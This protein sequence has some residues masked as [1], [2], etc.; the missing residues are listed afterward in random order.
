MPQV[1]ADWVRERV[2]PIADGPGAG[3]V[4]VAWVGRTSTD[5][6]QDP[7]GSLLR[8]LRVSQAA[9]PEGCVIVAHFY[10]VESGRKDLAHRGNGA[11]WSVPI[12]RDGGV[13][14]LLD[15]AEGPAPGF[16]AVICEQIDRIARGT[17]YGTLI[18]HRLQ[19]AG[20]RLWAADEPFEVT[21]R[22][23]IVEPSSILTRRVKQGV[24]EWY[25]LDMLKRARGGYETHT[26]QGYSVGKAPYGY[27]AN[28]VT[29]RE[30]EQVRG[31]GNRG[32]VVNG[33]GR[34]RPW[35]RIRS[36]RRWCGGSSG[37]GSAPGRGTRPSPTPS[38]PIP[39]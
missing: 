14:D 16:T 24:A 4:E 26:E 25:A 32:R 33:R 6:Q 27:R 28:T 36:R 17:Y 13:V 20:V 10:D 30:S 19:A 29:L 3:L 38:T 15:R 11:A 35:W 12:P 31:K 37:G 22:A 34:S 7:V 39:S 18:E 9:L 5:D 8:Q 1:V 23:G 21:A 2:G